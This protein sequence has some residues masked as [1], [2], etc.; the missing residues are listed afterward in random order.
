MKSAIIYYSYSGNT[1][2]V[3]EGLADYLKQKGEVE[4]IELKALDESDKFLIQAGRGFRKARAKIAPINFNLGNYDLV[5]LGTPVWGFGPAPAMNTF[6]DE[7]NNVQNKTALI[8]TTYGSGAGNNRCLD[9]MQKI[10]A[11]KGAKD[12]KRFSVQQFKVN[13]RDFVLSKIKEILPL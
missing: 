1:K 5:C 7:C 3:V 9:Y 10:L 11:I 4:I 8:F 2:K 12:F 13:D 6:L